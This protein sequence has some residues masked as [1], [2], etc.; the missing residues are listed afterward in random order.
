[1]VRPCRSSNG[2]ATTVHWTTLIDGGRLVASISVAPDA[3][4]GARD[5]TITNSDGRQATLV[6]ALAIN[7]A[8][9]IASLDPSSRGQGAADQ[10]V[11]IAGSDCPADFVSGGGAVS[12]SGDGI[13][14]NSVTCNV[15]SELVVNISVAPDARSVPAT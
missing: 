1:M 15:S 7:L 11:A 8:P 4:V 14:V 3:L 6:G 9:S 12:F 2:G 5:V 10:D 13:T